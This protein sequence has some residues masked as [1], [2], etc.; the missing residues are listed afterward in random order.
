MSRRDIVLGISLMTFLVLSFGLV[1]PPKALA[2]DYPN[3]AIQFI[4]Q[5]APGGVLDLGARLI[6]AGSAESLGQPMV[7]L[8][9]PGAGGA[10]GTDFIAK[11][12]P[13]GYTLGLGPVSLAILK[14]INPTLSFDP[15]KDLT[16]ICRLSMGSNVMVVRSDSPLNTLDKLIDYARKNPGKLNYGSSGVG[17]SL[18]F[19]GELFQREAGIQMVHVPYKGGA[20]A[21][22]ALL[23]GHIDLTFNNL[24]EAVEQI[25]G[26]KV[27][28]LA[29]TL[30]ER[31]PELPQIPSV[32]EK[33]YP[34]AVITSWTGVVGP[35]GLPKPV[36]DKISAYC[37]KVVS[38]PNILKKLKEF[39]VTPA[40][41]GPEEYGRFI[42]SEIELY[43]D[44][45]KRANIKAE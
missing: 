36:V 45:A 19:A 42:G 17:G 15:V 25:K 38:H 1:T 2:S 32:A 3:K 11:A 27:I 29:V 30:P 31:Y 16:P 39:W 8:N 4:V 24:Q 43:K 37:Q 6:A 18:H 44:L 9:K 7:I 21:L 10:L 33:G 20:P 35:A 13:D 12:K 22:M 41:L 14:A 23:G 5:Y 40:Y 34:K 28:P 26:G